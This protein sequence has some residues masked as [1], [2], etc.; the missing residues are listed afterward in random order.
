MTFVE[1]W[2]TT[3]AALY[4]ETDGQDLVEYSLLLAFISLAVIGLMRGFGSTINQVFSKIGSA[5]TSV[6]AS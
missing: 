6:A 4:Q 3:L 1:F 5:L 2:K